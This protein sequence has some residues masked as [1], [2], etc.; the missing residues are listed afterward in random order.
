MLAFRRVPFLPGFCWKPTWL[1]CTDLLLQLFERQI[2]EDAMHFNDN[3]AKDV[4]VPEQMPEEDPDGEDHLS[5][6]LAR[7]AAPGKPSAQ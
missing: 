3:F 1:S 2:E 6:P 4:P 7:A 5:I